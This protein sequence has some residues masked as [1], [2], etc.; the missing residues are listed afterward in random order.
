MERLKETIQKWKQEAEQSIAN[1]KEPLVYQ[2]VIDEIDRRLEVKQELTWEHYFDELIKVLVKHVA[3]DSETGEISTCALYRCDKC[4]FKAMIGDSDAD[5]IEFTKERL[6]SPY[7]P[8][9]KKPKLTRE[10]EE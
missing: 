1:L 4:L 10:V 5:C 3:V 7:K 6:L 2:K 8:F 9:K